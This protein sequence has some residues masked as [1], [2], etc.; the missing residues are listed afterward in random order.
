MFFAITG[1]R[2]RSGAVRALRCLPILLAITLLWGCATTDNG[3]VE[4]SDNGANVQLSIASY[5]LD[6]PPTTVTVTI[7]NSLVASHRL[8]ELVKGPKVYQLRLT[9]GHHELIARANT[10]LTKEVFPIFVHGH[11][12]QITLTYQQCVCE[13]MHRET[14]TVHFV[15]NQM[16]MSGR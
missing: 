1:S 6:H 3:N 4:R 11:A 15:L 10:G 5:L 7:D 2:L 8:E 16:E 9:P 12:E 13:E 14:D